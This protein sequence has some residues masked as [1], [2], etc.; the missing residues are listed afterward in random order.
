MANRTQQRPSSRSHF[1]RLAGTDA[2]DR[3][4]RFGRTGRPSRA[5]TGGRVAR[6]SASSPSRARFGR[7][8]AARKPT[9]RS[10]LNWLPFGGSGAQRKSSGKRVAGLAGA[11]GATANKKASGGGGGRSAA[12]LAALAGLAGLALKNRS[13]LASKL[14]RGKSSE[15]EAIAFAAPPTTTTTTTMPAD[16]GPV[17]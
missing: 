10:P 7:S 15:P 11:F 14:G 4:G 6:R 2:A 3:A 12:G 8:S 16:A 17:V 5:S 13:K 9:S 1:P